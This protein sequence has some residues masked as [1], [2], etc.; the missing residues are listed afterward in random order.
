MA[1]LSPETNR[2]V[3]SPPPAAPET[4]TQAQQLALFQALL[5]TVQHFFGGFARLFHGVTDPRAPA[6]ITYPLP[7]VLATGVLMFLLRL[8]AR[9]QIGQL[10]RGNSLVA[11][12]YQLLF[13][14]AQC[15]HGDTLNDLCRR[16]AVPQVQE[17]VAAMTETL[18][19]RKVLYAHRLLDQYFLV[20]IDGTGVL[21]F[22]E[23]HC[24][25]CLTRTDKR[26]TVYYH[27]VLEAKLVT[28]TG[29]AFSLMTEF[30]ENPTVAPTKQD[31]ELNAFYRWPPG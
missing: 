29:L 23:R 16:L 7:T 11:A 2:S 5:V 6:D 1:D 3:S 14:V 24:P 28:A 13:Q 15:P 27:P 26:G 8:G 12:K 21:T 22:T 10:L 19:R 18:I 17:A 4:E 25:H 9:R 31:C 20:V 30:I